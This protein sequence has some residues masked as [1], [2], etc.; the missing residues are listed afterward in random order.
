MSN[1]STTPRHTVDVT[2]ATFR[3][4]IVDY[5]MQVPVLV[6]FWAEW[7]EPCRTLGPVLERF[8][9]EYRGAFRLAKVDTDKEQRLAETFGVQSLPTVMLIFQGQVVDHFMGALPQHEVKRF[10]D[11][12][13]ERL[14]IE[15]PLGDDPPADPALAERFWRQKLQKAPDDGAAT[16]SLAR[17]L[18]ARGALDEARTGFAKIQAAQPEYSAAQA[19][20]A[21]L[22]MAQEVAAAGG[23]AAVKARLEAD[24]DDREARYLLA[25]AAAATGHFVA[26]LDELVTLVGTAPAEIRERAKTAVATVFEAAGRD[27]PEIE[28]LRRKLARLLF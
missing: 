18:V 15:A 7:C 12:S 8:A 19:A 27:I 14:G 11:A 28:Q 16:L 20:L 1:L 6:D 26:A 10:I 24:A 5:S 21:T 4:D 23:L 17:L 3:A 13:L 9:E 22:N 25:C 2:E